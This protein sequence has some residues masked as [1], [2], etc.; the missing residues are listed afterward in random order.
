MTVGGDEIEVS[1]MDGLLPEEHVEG[2]LTR[3]GDSRLSSGK[4]TKRLDI[5]YFMYKT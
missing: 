4:R 3:I 5:R 2:V 1:D